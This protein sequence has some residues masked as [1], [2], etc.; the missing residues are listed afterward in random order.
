MVSM[1][2]LNMLVNNIAYL[3]IPPNSLGEGWY[4][5]ESNDDLSHNKIM[6]DFNKKICSTEFTDSLS[7]F[8]YTL[9]QDIDNAQ[10][11]IQETYARIIEKQSNFDG[12]DPLPWAIT[13]M[14][15][16]FY[17]T[18]R[19]KKEYQLNDEKNQDIST[20]KTLEDL[21]LAHEN[22]DK[23][24]ARM[25]FCLKKLTNNDRE[26]IALKQQD[27]SYQHIA[28]VLDMSLAN[29]RVRM[30]RARDLLRVCLEGV[31]A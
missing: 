16:Y 3:T 5:F 22:E 19:K 18:H 2:P 30:T 28:E 21:H 25:H 9:A 20:G 23:V 11:L 13:I 17:D 27:F 12:D 29:A 24:K 10:D 14:R 6:S 4:F 7:R 15:N 31:V 8:A 26:I 1:P